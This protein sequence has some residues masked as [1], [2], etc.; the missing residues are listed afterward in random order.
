MVAAVVTMDEKHVIS[1][2]CQKKLYCQAMLGINK[3][4]PQFPPKGIKNRQKRK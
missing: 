4:I 3:C 2:K 1:I